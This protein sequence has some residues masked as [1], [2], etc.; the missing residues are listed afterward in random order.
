MAMM[1]FK[2]D[3]DDGDF[4]SDDGDDDVQKW[5][6]YPKAMMVFKLFKSDDDDDDDVQKRWPLRRQGKYKKPHVGWDERSFTNKHQNT[7][8]K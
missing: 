3:G 5:W 2:S 8:T 1:M 7:N 6:W 4:Q